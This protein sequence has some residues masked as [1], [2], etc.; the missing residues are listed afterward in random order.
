M[1]ISDWSSDVCSSDLA[2]AGQG[3]LTTF[4][5]I[6]A[7]QMGTDVDSI[8]VIEGDTGA[9]PY[10]TNTFAS[11]S[12]VTGGGAVIRAS[13]KV[14]AK[15]RRIAAHMLECGDMDIELREGKAFVTGADRSVSFEEVAQ[16]AYSMN[17]FSQIGRASC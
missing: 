14:T 12:A 5:Q 16:T 11:R 9:T 13:E 7:D 3:H 15:M 1:R 4:A 17:A 10:G 8:T 2:N 6:L